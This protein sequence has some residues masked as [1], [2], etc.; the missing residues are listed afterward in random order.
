MGMCRLAVVIAILAT[1]PATAGDWPGWRG[2]ARNGTSS[3]TGLNWQ[4]P[5]EGPKVLWKASVGTGFSCIAVAGKRAYTLGNRDQVDTLHCLDAETGAELWKH[6][7]PCKLDPK[8]Y[9][10]GPM[11]TPA[12][13]DGRVYTISKFGDCF[14]LNAETG[15]V[16]WS[17]KFEPPVR[18]E[19]DYQT[20]WGFAGSILIA[21]DRLILPV[22]TAGLAVDKLTGKT[23]WDN[24]PGYSGYSS[25][26]QFETDG[27]P[28][29][30]FV[31]GHEVV[32]A[33]IAD[34]QIRWKIPWKTTWDQN[35]SDVIVADNK[36]FVS[37]GHA[38]GCGLF[39]LST[40]SPS[41]LWRNKNMKTYLSNCVL[42]QGSLYGFDDKELQCLNWQTGEVRW[43][44]P[45][46]GL[47][48]LILA[49]GKL[50]A[51]LE[52]GILQIVEATAEAYKPLVSAKVLTGRC[53]SA[54]SLAHGRLYVRNAVGDVLCLNLRK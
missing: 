10:G 47:G 7:Y 27:Q 35:A 36:L 3:E 18:T 21:G 52:N 54:P 5:A 26:I 19:A 6:S 2:P 29:F 14:C 33:N 37:S 40:G 9:E 34:G 53:W 49:E 15:A 11:A 32:A 20:W 24:G 48:S 42:W 17:A 41:P 25:P 12:I 46:L 4:W 13:E 23:L 45:R 28:C 8:A 50:I 1:V 38:V 51:L 30:A 44:S 16:I 31:S 22:G 39:D 43:S